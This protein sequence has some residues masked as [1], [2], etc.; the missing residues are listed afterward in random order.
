MAKK[1]K[2]NKKRSQKREEQQQDNLQ[3]DRQEAENAIPGTGAL[4]EELIKNEI[5]PNDTD[6]NIVE[7]DSFAD[8]S[9]E[10]TMDENSAVDFTLNQAP[11][12][13]PENQYENFINDFTDD[14]DILD[15]FMERQNY[16]NGVGGSGK[17][18][19]SLEEHNS[20]TPELSGG[21][22]DAS[23]DYS[24]ASGEESVGGTVPTPDQDVVDELGE[25]V[26]V[27][28]DDE[29]DLHTE[30]KLADR[31]KRRYEL[32]PDSGDPGDAPE[33]EEKPFKDPEV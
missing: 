18:L 1:A 22:V 25:A 33:D 5:D 16:S 24:D 14:P 11:S 12:D 13:D 9:E 27:T 28:Y 26:G 29:E 8:E 19:D 31:D 7:L 3:E 20:K 32:D 21:D 15:D 2:G 10:L 4:N 30:D 6:I 17:L 23:W